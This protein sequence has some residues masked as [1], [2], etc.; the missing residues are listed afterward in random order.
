MKNATLAPPFFPSACP[1]VA[2][3]ATCRAHASLTPVAT[4]AHFCFHK[5]ANAMSRIGQKK[6]R[7]RGSTK[8]KSRLGADVMLRGDVKWK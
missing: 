1:T 7:A 4:V 8:K 2:R 5:E 3:T 6:M